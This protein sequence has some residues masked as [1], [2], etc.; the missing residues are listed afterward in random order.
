MYNLALTITLTPKYI[1][2][3]LTQKYIEM[4]PAQ[5]GFYLFFLF[6]NEQPTLNKE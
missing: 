5:R 2:M 4:R 6:L 3:R 1:E